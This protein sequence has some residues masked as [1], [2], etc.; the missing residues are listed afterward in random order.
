[1]GSDSLG[2]VYLEKLKQENIDI[3]H[4]KIQNNIHTGIAQIIVTETGNYII[5]LY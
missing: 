5:N 2:E 4:V 3:S 1:L